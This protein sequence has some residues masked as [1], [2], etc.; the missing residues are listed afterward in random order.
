MVAKEVSLENQ[1]YRDLRDHLDHVDNQVCRDQVETEENLDL[2]VCLDSL[3][4]ADKL[5]RAVREVQMALRE[6]T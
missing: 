3:D 4:P 1:V 2:Q 5:E 6:K